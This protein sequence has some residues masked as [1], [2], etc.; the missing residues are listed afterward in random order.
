[1]KNK[2]NMNIEGQLSIFDLIPPTIAEEIEPIDW[3]KT[4]FC[5]YV[6]YS[7]AGVRFSQCA[8]DKPGCSE[9]CEAH[10]VFYAMVESLRPNC[11]PP[12][13]AAAHAAAHALLGIPTA[14]DSNGRIKK[15]EEA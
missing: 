10:E 8:N 4:C 12:T 11:E 5:S 14:Y 15:N 2:N 13:L 1:M 3:E 7:G 9:E 6:T